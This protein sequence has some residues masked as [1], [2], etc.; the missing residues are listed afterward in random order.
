MRRQQLAYLTSRCAK[1]IIW[2]MEMEDAGMKHVASDRNAWLPAQ[3]APTE[4]EPNGVLYPCSRCA[5]AI[6]GLM[7]MEDAGMKH[8]A[9]DRNAWLPAQSAPT[10]FEPR[11]GHET[12]KSVQ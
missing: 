10:E 9:S 7:E 2:L 3:S 12:R 4:S 8:V 11:K 5:K 1:A 6:I